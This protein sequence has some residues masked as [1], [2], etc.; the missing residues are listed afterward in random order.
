[1]QNLTLGDVVWVVSQSHNDVVCTRGEITAKNN[2]SIK[3][4]AINK[5]IT[6]ELNLSR[7]RIIIIKN[8]RQARL[9]WIA[10]M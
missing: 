4:T 9:V 7:D 2:S 8:K 5:K 10:K 3:L 6:I 1:M